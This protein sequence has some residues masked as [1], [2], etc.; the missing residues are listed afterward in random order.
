VY[1]LLCD[2]MEKRNR[3]KT[4]P[5]EGDSKE[6]DKEILP[7][8]KPTDKIKKLF[9]NRKEKLLLFSTALLYL[10]SFCAFST[11]APFYTQEAL[12]KGASTTISGLVFASY[13]L[14]IVILSPFIGKYLPVLGPTFVLLAGS[15]LEAGGE[16]LFG[17]LDEMPSTTSFIV[18]SFII[19]MLTAVGSAFSQTATIAI[20]SY[21]FSDNMST[22]FG[23][24]ELASGV[25]LMIGPSLGG[26]LYDAGGFRL[27]FVV[28]GCLVLASLLIV[29]FTLPESQELES[30][31]SEKLAS[32][33]QTL[34]IPGVLITALCVIVAGTAVSFFD[35]TLAVHLDNISQG[36]LSKTE[37]GLFF[38]CQTFFYTLSAPLWG[39]L[40]D[41]KISGRLAMIIGLFISALAF[42][43]LG[44]APFFGSFLK[45][46]LVLTGVSLC[47]AGFSMGPILVPS[48]GC[49]QTAAVN[50]GLEADLPLVSLL[51]GIYGSCFYIGSV[52][53]PLYGGLL[54]EYSTFGWASFFIAVLLFVQ[55]IFL[56][57]FTWWERKYRST[58][59][60]KR[61]DDDNDAKPMIA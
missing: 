52:I 2:T 3:L 54:L 20:M 41:K 25:G 6:M 29:K 9:R 61:M 8:P 33:T 38:L 13:P 30:M 31:E 14:V 5:F 56:T 43:F 18:L 12:K 21:I 60:F 42:M 58:N 39:Y 46:N 16:I 40:A 34:K 55:G 36:K 10:S 15:F 22:I 53:G 49:M 7:I 11:I 26:V 24:F 19:R 47:V 35:A 45:P 23:I 44:P 51:S 32:L 59:I 1:K 37:T 17:F 27:P 48:I 50:G 28:I 4:M 57:M